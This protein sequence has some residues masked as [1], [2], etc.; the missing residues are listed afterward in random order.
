MAQVGPEDTR[1][2][3]AVIAAAAGVRDVQRLRGTVIVDVQDLHAPAQILQ[4]VG[5]VGGV[6]LEVEGATVPRG[7]PVGV[8][9]V[10][11]DR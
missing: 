8:E 9:L 5:G 2:D 11:Q 7:V 6:E 10:A 1:G 3:G 4:R